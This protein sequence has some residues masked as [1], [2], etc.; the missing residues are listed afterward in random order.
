MSVSEPSNASEIIR[1]EIELQGS[2]TF[3]RFMEL[4]LYAPAC[5]YY[6]RGRDPFGKSGDFYTAEQV[7]PVFGIL[8]GQFMGAARDELG[9][10]PE[11]QVVELGAGREEMAAALGE[12]NYTGIDVGR[13]SLPERIQGVVFANEF[14]DALPV[15]L[16]VRRGDGFIEQGVAYEDGRF[17][18][19]D[20]AAAAGRTLEYLNRWYAGAPADSV[21]EVNL[22]ALDWIDAIAKRLERGWLAIVD[23]GYTSREW[24]RHQQGT[25]LS[26][27]R[28]SASDDVLSDPGEHD[29]TAH[30]PFTVL[31]DHAIELGFLRR[32]F[33]T[34]ARLLLDAG[35][36]DQFAAA[37]ASE[38]EAE[39][40][41]RRL[42]LKMLLFEM[43]ETFRVLLLAK[44]GGK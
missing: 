42:Q 8:I 24:A 27:R 6:T 14:F 7:Q 12:F 22:R 41:R 5:G 3:E 19:V 20:G 39:A 30:V 26:Y 25:L 23:Y 44:T 4:A 28:H 31:E 38:S 43:G 37:L 21:I 2:I 17:I 10:G 40:L 13:G 29:I 1:A 11:F 9:M 34:L 16:V 36:K 35:D 18:Q 33:E 32:R 15:Q